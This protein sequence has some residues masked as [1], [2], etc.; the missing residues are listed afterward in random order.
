VRST[1]ASATHWGVRDGRVN[2]TS[3]EL[4]VVDANGKELPLKGRIEKDRIEA[5]GYV[6]TRE[7]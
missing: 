6:G 5:D 3:I 4:T 2:G 1:P 7:L